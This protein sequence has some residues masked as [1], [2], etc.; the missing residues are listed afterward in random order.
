MGVI[1]IN[2]FAQDALLPHA[3]PEK[4]LRYSLSLPVATAVVAMRKFERRQAR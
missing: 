3:Q 4:L 1:A 2:V